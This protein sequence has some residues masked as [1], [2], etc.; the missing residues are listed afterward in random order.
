L[1]RPMQHRAKLVPDNLEHNAVPPTR[2]KPSNSFSIYQVSNCKLHSGTGTK[3]RGDDSYNGV[4]IDTDAE[5]TVIG[6]KQARA[7]C[8]MMK[9]PLKRYPNGNVYIFGEDR[10]KSLGSISI[11]IPTSRNAF[12]EVVAYVV[13]ANVPF[14]L[15][16]DTL[17]KFGLDVCISTNRLRCLGQDWDIETEKKRGHLY[18]KDPTTTS[19]LYTRSEL[20]KLHRAF[21]HPSTDK[22]YSLLKRSK[23]TEVHEDTRRQLRQIVKACLTC[24]TFASQPLRFSVRLPDEKLVFNDELIM[25]LLWLDGEPALHVVD[26]ATRFGAAVFL[27]GQD[28]EQVWSAFLE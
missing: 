1:T 7:Y 13:T 24:Q 8:R 20:V 27:E 10:R 18:I 28:V 21:F 12:I 17:Q 16:L 15:D 6:L 5:R 2:D 9:R 19:I 25:D 23:P 26:T 11:R 4:C 14:I 22:L 3:L